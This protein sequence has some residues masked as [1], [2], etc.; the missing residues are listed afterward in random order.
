VPPPAY[1][2]SP[3]SSPT[4]RLSSRTEERTLRQK[5]LYAVTPAFMLG[6]EGCVYLLAFK[7]DCILLKDGQLG[8]LGQLIWRFSDLVIW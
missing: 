7:P 1:Q 2:T 8:L 6:I 5:S 4:F 3:K